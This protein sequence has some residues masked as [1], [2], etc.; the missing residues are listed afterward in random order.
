MC[1]GVRLL[2]SKA[3]GSQ[4]AGLVSVPVPRSLRLQGERGSGLEEVS[5]EMRSSDETTEDVPLVSRTLTSPA[6]TPGGLCP[7]FREF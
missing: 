3:Q 4:R 5:V 1:P 7:K 6:P 2:P